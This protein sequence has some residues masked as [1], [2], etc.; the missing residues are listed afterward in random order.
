MSNP[1]L[2]Q[3]GP[4]ALI[5]GGSEGIGLSFARQLAAA[6]INLVLIARRQE[7]LEAAK[8]HL[9]QTYPIQVQTHAMDLTSTDVEEHLSGIIKG[10]EVGLLIYNAGAIHGA[11]LFLN[12][13]LDKAR[14]LIHLNCLGPAIFCHL[15]GNAMRERGRGGI[16]LMSS[17]SGLTGGAYIASYA[18]TK[19]FDII[20]AEGLWAELAPCG[21][22]VLGLVAGATDTP[23]MAASGIDFET[24]HAMDAMDVAREGLEQ[25][26]FG[27][28]H[29]AGDGNRDGAAI[30][31]GEDRRQSVTLMSAGSAG[32]YGLPLPD[33]PDS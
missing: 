14:K 13:P 23:A 16:I 26:P 2:Q 5:A 27:P 8:E 17:L 10:L 1:L 20:L 21:V 18:A 29:V 25:L 15:L 24:G 19:A 28:I 4:W 31:R 22:H 12:E 3:Y 11:G 33:F 7:P 6:G 32:L 30:L 9:L